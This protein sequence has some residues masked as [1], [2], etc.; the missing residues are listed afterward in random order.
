VTY[1]VVFGVCCAY[2]WVLWISRSPF[3]SADLDAMTEREA[4][5]LGLLS[6]WLRHRR[7]REGPERAA[8]Q[9]A[10]LEARGRKP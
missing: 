6:R 4:Y 9:K 3:S 7:W 8:K 10:W 2:G 1:L 5:E